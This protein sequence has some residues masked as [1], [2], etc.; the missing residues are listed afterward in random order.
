[1]A[2][3]YQSPAQL[4]GAG[5][6][7]TITAINAIIQPRRTQQGADMCNL[8]EHHLAEQE[9]IFG[10]SLD[11]V[12][13]N[14]PPREVYP[15]GQGIIYN[16][17]GELRVMTWGFPLALKSKRTGEPLRPKPVNNA[18]TDKLD[19]FMWR[20]SFAK[21]RC[22]IPA[23]RFAEAEGA[24]GSMTRTW[25]SPIGQPRLFLAG[26]WRESIEWGGVYSMVMTESAP[27]FHA[28]M[29]VCQCY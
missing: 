20:D 24:K 1:M 27:L 26:L 3:S 6:D 18:R 10:K 13:G 5:R 19:S 8:Y 23:T 11:E 17:L 14:L 22:L 16:A 12:L 21:R 2:Q 29:T 7:C 28:S 25:F 4:T 15:G 9:K